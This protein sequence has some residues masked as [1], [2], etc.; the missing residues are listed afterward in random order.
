[1]IIL[2]DNYYGKASFIIR[3]ARALRMSDLAP[4]NTD[5]CAEGQR[6]R[7]TVH[8]LTAATHRMYC[9]NSML[10]SLN[11]KNGKVFL[12]NRLKYEQTLTVKDLLAQVCTLL[13]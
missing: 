10:V 11:F 6:M 5:T 13:N 12:K 4:N 3:E 9:L 2:V 7:Q 1:M 8:W